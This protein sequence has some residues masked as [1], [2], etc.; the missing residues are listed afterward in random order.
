MKFKFLLISILFIVSCQKEF[1]NY[2]DCYQ[3]PDNNIIST[4]ELLNDSVNIEWSTSDG[5][6]QNSN[7]TVKNILDLDRNVYSV[8]INGRSTPTNFF[9]SDTNIFVSMMLNY[10]TI[11][12][13][14]KVFAL[15]PMFWDMNFWNVASDAPIGV[16][17]DSSKIIIYSDNIESSTYEA[18][19]CMK[20]T[21]YK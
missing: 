10:D 5:Y 21:I 17:E 14:W 2:R 1:W 20:L 4:C 11:N 15:K 8:E 16:I 19:M 13:T 18:T 3:I 12:D 9:P 6:S 7:T